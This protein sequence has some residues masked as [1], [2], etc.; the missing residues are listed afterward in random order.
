MIRKV[1]IGGIRFDVESVNPALLECDLNGI[2]I[3]H[4]MI[5]DSKSTISELSRLLLQPTHTHQKGF[6]SIL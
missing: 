4:R 2:C 3:E 1:H 6:F 5:Q